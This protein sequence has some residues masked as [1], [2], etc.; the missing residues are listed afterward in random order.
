MEVKKPINTRM[1]T[2]QC[3]ECLEGEMLPTGTV[4]LS[5]PPKYPHKCTKCGYEMTFSVQYPYVEYFNP[6]EEQ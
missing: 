1:V 5:N 2:Y 6:G 4:L 3:D